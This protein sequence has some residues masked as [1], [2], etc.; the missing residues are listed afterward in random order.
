MSR[1]DITPWSPI[2][3]SAWSRG[4]VIPQVSRA[5]APLWIEYPSSVAA[6]ATNRAG[7]RLASELLL[8][9]R[10]ASLRAMAGF[11]PEPL[12]ERA[13]EPAAQ[14]PAAPAQP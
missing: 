2:K 11:P 5:T 7:R 14:H 3:V 10:I 4:A 12:A 6:R 9:E 1:V 8:E 13:A